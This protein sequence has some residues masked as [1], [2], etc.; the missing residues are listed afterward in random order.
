[1]LFLFWLFIYKIKANVTSYCISVVVPSIT[2]DSCSGIDKCVVLKETVI[3]V[4]I[5]K[6]FQ[7]C[8]A[9]IPFGFI[10]CFALKL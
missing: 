7:N 5:H 4:G 6:K 2:L 1:M 9:T 8:F 3:H 10:L